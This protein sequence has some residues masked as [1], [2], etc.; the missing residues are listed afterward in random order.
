MNPVT[1]VAVILFM[2]AV[3][4]VQHVWRREWRRKQAEHLETL[5]YRGPDCPGSHDEIINS[6]GRPD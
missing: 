1:V 3:W 4:G 2:V 6:D 5:D